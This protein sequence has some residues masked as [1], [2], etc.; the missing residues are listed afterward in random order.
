VKLRRGCD[1]L[2]VQRLA[3]KAVGLPRECIVVHF[4]S[5]TS[6]AYVWHWGWSD[7]LSA[8]P[9]LFLDSTCS[10]SALI[11]MQGVGQLAQNR[12]NIGGA[13]CSRRAAGRPCPG[14]RNLETNRGGRLSV[15]RRWNP[16]G[17]C[18]AAF[19]QG[20]SMSSPRRRFH[21][22]RRDFKWPNWTRCLKVEANR[23]RRARERM[24]F[25]HP[26]G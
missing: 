14:C 9:G 15:Q 18:I 26:E 4:V 2:P 24:D 8:V 16:R 1:R 7:P 22:K 3:L 6:V 21:E 10:T 23:E 25:A 5:P 13:R 17:A 12:E 11:P 20:L 19:D